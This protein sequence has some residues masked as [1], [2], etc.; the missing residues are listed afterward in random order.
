VKIALPIENGKLAGHFGHAPRF[1]LVTVEKQGVKE[2]RLLNPPPHE[3]GS[4]PRWLNE[5]G[6]THVIC[7]GIGGRAVDLLK[8]AGVDV[9]AGVPSMDPA[10]A[11]EDFLAGRLT[12]ASGPTCTGHGDGEHHCRH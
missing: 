6:T 12:G 10:Q 1:A 9:V 2:S 3:P 4:L 8:A 7:G 5:I 11:V